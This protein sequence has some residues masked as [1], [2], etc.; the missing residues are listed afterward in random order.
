MIIQNNARFYVNTYFGIQVHPSY[1]FHVNGYAN[2]D[3]NSVR[4]MYHNFNGFGWGDFRG[5]AVGIYSVKSIGSNEAIFVHSDRRIKKEITEINDDSSL[6]KLRLLKPSY[7]RYR[8]TISRG[9][10]RTVEGFIAQ[11]VEEVLPNAVR[12]H[13]DK[14][15][16]IMSKA[17]YAQDN[18]GNKIITLSEYNT[19]DLEVDASGNVF[20]K[21]FIY[22]ADPEDY[23]HEF[24]EEYEEGSE[25][26]EAEIVEVLSSTELRI[27]VSE[28]TNEKLT[29][30]LL[31]YGQEVDNKCWLA[32]DK[33]FT[34]GISALQEVDRQLQAEKEK[35]TAI[36]TKISLLETQ[37]NDVSARLS[38][39]ENKN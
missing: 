5:V 7:Y 9:E 13:T 23:V 17:T 22:P 10:N 8:D 14:I 18:N 21:L 28:E 19:A 16:N 37:R 33:I 27:E 1:P 32:K 12:V 36:E 30:E 3:L 11:E 34:V 24:N 35:T 38:V 15:P 25:P 2:A 31:I 26:V 6:Q 20:T 4:W 29:E 39:L